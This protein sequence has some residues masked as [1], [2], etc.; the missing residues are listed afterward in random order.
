M[1][2]VYT[3]YL[4][5]SCIIVTLSISQ[6]FNGL[7]GIYVCGTSLYCGKYR[8]LHLIVLLFSRVSEGLVEVPFA[9]YF[10]R[11]EHKQNSK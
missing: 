10:L 4:R 5:L 3:L 1:H 2:R 8:H 9:E 7:L 11:P 6:R